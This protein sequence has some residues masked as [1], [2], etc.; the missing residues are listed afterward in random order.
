MT[1]TLARQGKNQTYD[2]LTRLPNNINITTE[3]VEGESLMLYLDSYNIA[4]ATG[5]AC[6]T[7]DSEPSHVLLAMGK[8]DTAARSSLR[9]TL[10]KESTKKQIDYLLNV[11]PGIVH[12]LRKT[13]L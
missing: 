10:G 11:L 6:T 13:K 4:A 3:G 12:E 1:Y 5:S 2:N 7:E 8:G 9:I